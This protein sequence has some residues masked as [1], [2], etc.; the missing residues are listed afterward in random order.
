MV[1]MFMCDRRAFLGIFNRKGISL[2]AVV[3]IMLIVA[4]LALV[5]VS[6]MS[7]GNISSITD[8]QAQQA[9]YLA[10]AGLEWYMEELENDSDWS[11][12][13]PTV[14]DQPYGAGTY[15]VSY[16]NPSTRVT[17]TETSAESIDVTAT[18][19]V[20]G[21]DGNNVQRVITHTVTKSTGS[22][23]FADFAIF[24]GGGDGT[25][26]FYIDKEQTITGDIF[27]NGDL[28]IDKDCTIT[29]DI[30]VTGTTD[31]HEDTTVSG[32]VTEGADPPA[33]QPTLAT[34]YYDDLII[35]ASGEPEGN[36]T[37][38]ND[39]LSGID[40]VN[41][42]VTIKN[43]LDG[44]GTIVATGTISIRKTA[45]IGDNITLIAD[46]D[47]TMGKNGDVGESVTFYSSSLVQIANGVVLGSGAGTNE[48]VVLLSPKDI[49]LK[50]NITITGFIFGANEVDI[51][52]PNLTLRGNLCGG[53]F[54]ELDNGAV[55]TKDDTKVD[56]GSIQG[57]D[58][59]ASTTITISYWQ[60]SL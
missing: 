1:K 3:I 39:T 41:G 24:F 13:P 21:W 5:V 6:T 60:E 54:T 46:S 36:V 52:K 29:G 31:I 40:Y 30:I 48:G 17:H 35:T 4:T 45:D 12:P 11:S 42:N 32:T 23:T 38:N 27:V 25:Y 7:S 51:D 49:V 47:L 8:M 19:K 53:I 18:G 22:D 10:Q 9:F 2:I 44:S 56:F 26:D 50:K 15:S 59:G 33:N 37:Y 20:T 58:T 16:I 34:A 43:E 14:T 55:I 57:F 28:E